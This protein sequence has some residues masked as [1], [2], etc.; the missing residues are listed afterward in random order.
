MPETVRT[1]VALDLPETILSAVADI[2]KDL[3]AKGLRMRW[4]PSRN[5]HLTLAFLGE[6]ER[7]TLGEVFGAVDRTGAGYTSFRLSFSGMGVFPNIRRPRV[8][9]LGFAGDTAR[10]SSVKKIMD[11]NLMSVGELSYRQDKRPFRAHLT[12]GRA[13]GRMDVEELKR[14]LRFY[15]H[16]KTEEFI[17]NLIH[18]YQSRLGPK[19]AVYTRLHTT[20]LTADA[21]YQPE[22]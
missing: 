4:V 3:R 17:I 7:D 15:S 5:M 11:G 1:F 20:R 8:L 2:Q 21:E 9:W 14:A 19:G 12:L 22:T 13:K 18:V 16:F 10:I 6:I